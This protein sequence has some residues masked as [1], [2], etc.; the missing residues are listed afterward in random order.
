MFIKQRNVSNWNY[1][2]HSLLSPKPHFRRDAPQK[3]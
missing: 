2:M 1:N 3:Q